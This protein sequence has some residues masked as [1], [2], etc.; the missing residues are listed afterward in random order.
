MADGICNACGAALAG[1]FCHRCGQREADTDW[2][3]AGAIARQFW[4]ELVNL[5]FKTVRS[6]AALFVPGRLA[7]E[8]IAGRQMRYLSPLKLYFLAAA[9]FFV[10][11]PRVTDFNFERQMALDRDGRVRALVAAHLAET[12]VPRELFAERFGRTLQ[13]V[14]TLMPIV[15]VLGMMLVLR[16]LFG[17]RF[18]WLGPHVVFALYYVAFY[19]V[20][21]LLMHGLNEH[22]DGPNMFVL[23]AVHYGIVLPY[24]FAALKRVYGESR[25]RT[26]RKTIAALA[27]TF[28]IDAPINFAGVVLSVKLT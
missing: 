22:F 17:A 9:L 1:E 25:G 14:Y 6:L 10:I 4:N 19:F 18:P 11:A 23:L 12:R 26:L 27:L 21:A 3:S 15:S 28:L 2:R 24:M 13:T 8:F 5:D 20:V 16:M 7:A